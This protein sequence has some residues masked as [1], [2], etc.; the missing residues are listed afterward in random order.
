MPVPRASPPARLLVCLSAR[1]L[2]P[3]FLWSFVP[4]PLSPFYV[5]WPVLTHIHTVI[6]RTKNVRGS[7]TKK[8]SSLLSNLPL[9]VRLSIFGFLLFYFFLFS[10][11]AL[12]HSKDQS[13]LN[14]TTLYPV[15]VDGGWCLC[16]RSDSLSLSLSLSLPVS[17]LC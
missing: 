7:V 17:L 9:F 3:L 2:V 8:K 4:A 12:A 15:A 14:S 16:P 5:S 11:F 1:S 13:V 6:A 10:V